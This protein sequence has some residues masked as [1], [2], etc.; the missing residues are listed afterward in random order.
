MYISIPFTFSTTCV[1]YC[2][3]Y[4]TVVRFVARDGTVIGEKRYSFG[5]ENWYSL[6][7]CLQSQT[8]DFMSSY[9]GIE[10]P[11]LQLTKLPPFASGMSRPE[12]NQDIN[13]TN[14]FDIDHVQDYNDFMNQMKKDRKFEKMFQDMVSHYLGYGNSMEKYKYNW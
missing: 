10:A 7:Y 13:V 14:H 11:P 12:V 8:L 2:F 9:S 1:Y 4:I 6:L 3:Q 5:G